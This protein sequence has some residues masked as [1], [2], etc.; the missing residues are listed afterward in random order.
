MITYL[1][2]LPIVRQEVRH[3]KE[4]EILSKMKIPTEVKDEK[5]LAA[6]DKPVFITDVKMAEDG[7]IRT[8]ISNCI[9][10]L[11]FYPL[12]ETVSLIAIYKRLF[13][14]IIK[15]FESQ[16]WLQK[17]ITLL[18]L[19]INF[20]I[21]PSW[22]GSLF[23]QFPILLKEE[24]WSQPIKEIRR[25]I[26]INPNLLNGLSLILEYDSAYRYRFQ[27]VVGE[28]KKENGIKEIP[29]LLD[30]LIARDYDTQKIKWDKIKKFSKLV[31]LIPRFR[32][33]AE[34][35]IK[36]ININEIKLSKEDIYHTN[37]YDSYNYR[38]LL[39]QQRRNENIQN[40]GG[41]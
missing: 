34:R 13:L 19:W 14:L 40:Y 9:E 27:D 22:L 17:I 2:L 41:I 37:Q 31:L 3:T 32:R 8:F 12:V 30:L 4:A 39:I 38:G 23:G 28:L 15:E 10:P 1:D 16:N 36:E 18:A 25:V 26:K 29:R 21:M 7:T 11:R 33:E 35:I 6:I 5:Y 24:H 20:D